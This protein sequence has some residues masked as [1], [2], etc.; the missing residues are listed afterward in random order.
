MYGIYIF[1]Y[2]LAHVFKEIDEIETFAF[3]LF[4]IPDNPN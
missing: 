3:M 1:I 4:P 2:W